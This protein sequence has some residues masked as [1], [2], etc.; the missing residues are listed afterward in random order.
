M[1]EQTGRKE[2]YAALN[3]E[4]YMQAGTQLKNLKTVYWYSGSFGY[5]TPL[6][7]MLLATLQSRN[8]N[9]LLM[10]D[11]P[12][13]Q[14]H[15]DSADKQKGNLFERFGCTMPESIAEDTLLLQG[16]MQDIISGS[17][18]SFQA[19]LQPLEFR[20]GLRK[21]SSVPAPCLLP[22]S[23]SVPVLRR[24]NNTYATIIRNEQT[25]GSRT[26]I[27]GINP[28]SIPDE[29][30]RLSLADK[31]LLW[32]E[33]VASGIDAPATIASNSP[34]TLK[35]LNNPF[36]EWARISVLSAQSGPA[37]IEL[38]NSAGQS[39][40]ILF[41]GMLHN[42]QELILTISAQGRPAGRYYA[43]IRQGSNTDFIPLMQ[44]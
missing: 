19:I 4:E 22:T 41:D 37:S 42:D 36:T 2:R 3:T 29:N 23:G 14:Y 11:A 25:N 40:G 39:A 13:I 15:L 33:P 34:F 18:G 10:A 5:I 44:L 24:T 12:L 16:R 35:A 7:D 28:I 20:S 32:L 38:F 43:V 31:A 9:I 6:D 26:V 27:F 1:L 8:V 30:I 17:T 21:Y